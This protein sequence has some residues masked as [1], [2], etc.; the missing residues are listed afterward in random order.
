ME[1]IKLKKKM[2]A[3]QNTLSQKKKAPAERKRERA[4]YVAS[5]AVRYTSIAQGFSIHH[6]ITL[7]VSPWSTLL[8][9]LSSPPYVLE[10]KAENS[11]QS[12]LDNRRLL[13]VV[14]DSGAPPVGRLERAKRGWCVDT[15]IA[16]VWIERWSSHSQ[17]FAIGPCKSFD[18]VVEP[19]PMFL[20]NNAPRIRVRCNL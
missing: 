20:C 6:S 19:F 14:D 17:P 7:L 10:V 12:L 4:K 13:F 16:A 15:T 18:P 11:P 2:T 5:K 1:M 8:W 9:S 3:R